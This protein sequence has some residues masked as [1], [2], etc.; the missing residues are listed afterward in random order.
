MTKAGPMEHILLSI[1]CRLLDGG[2]VMGKTRYCCD[3]ASVRDVRLAKV[4]P[5]QRSRVVTICLKEGENGQTS[6][7]PPQA[8]E[9]ILE[10]RS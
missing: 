7:I 10:R 4:Q 3:H 8:Q 9:V 5:I 6:N 2:Y 1:P